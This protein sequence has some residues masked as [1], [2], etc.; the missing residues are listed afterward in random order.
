MHAESVANLAT[1]TAKR[2]GL[3]SL[4]KFKSLNREGCCCLR[5]GEKGEDRHGEGP[6]DSREKR[7]SIWVCC[8]RCEIPVSALAAAEMDTSNC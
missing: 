8:L 1:E 7:G 3:H 4:Y 6:V 5:L 2:E